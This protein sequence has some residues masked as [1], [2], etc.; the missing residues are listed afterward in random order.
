MAG[1]QVE[2]LLAHLTH[3][4]QVGA[5]GSFCDRLGVVVVVLLT[6]HERLHID[7]WNDAWLMAEL[8]QS[9]ADE[10]RTQAGFHPDDARWQLL[11]R[12]DQ[13]QPLDLTAEC[14]LAVSA[15]ANE[16]EDFL[17]DIDADRGKW[18]NGGIHGLLL[19]LMRS[20]LGPRRGGSSRSIPLGVIRRDAIARS[21]CFGLDK[22]S[23][24]ASQGSVERVGREMEVQERDGQIPRGDR[25]REG[26][27]GLDEQD[28]DPVR[29]LFYAVVYVD[30]GID[31]LDKAA[32]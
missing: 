12:L 20:S 11:E 19:R 6:L 25:P 14:D 16:V 26:R 17:A 30:A 2:L 5:K 9:T 3:G 7:S 4:A 27:R 29:P 24:S 15:E 1:L 13:R 10:V 8:A 22:S 23:S 32:D 28:E 31:T 21:R 18:C